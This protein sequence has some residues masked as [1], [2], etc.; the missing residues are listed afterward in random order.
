MPLMHTNIMIYRL[1]YPPDNKIFGCDPQVYGIDAGN[2]FEGHEGQFG[3]IQKKEIIL[4]KLVF[5]KKAKMTD[6]LNTSSSSIN[7][8][9]KPSFYKF[10]KP[11]LGEHQAWHI[12]I[13]N[14]QYKFDRSKVAYV[15]KDESKLEF[16]NY[17][18]LHLSYPNNQFINMEKSEFFIDSRDDYLKL[19]RTSNSLKVKEY[20]SSNKHELISFKSTEEHQNYSIELFNEKENRKVILP[21]KIV[22]NVS[23]NTHDIFRLMTNINGLNCHCVSEKIKIEIE[24]QGFTGMTFEPIIDFNPNINVELV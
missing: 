13:A 18:I 23:D 7:K 4:P 10:L 1:D 16:Y 20:F 9:I 6:I 15:V 21:R 12:K 5:K 22:F 2:L 19:V 8:I 11:Y 14:D 17:V 3:P 24:N